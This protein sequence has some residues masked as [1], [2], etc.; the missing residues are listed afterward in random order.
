M[1]IQENLCFILHPVENNF[2]FPVDS[3]RKPMR[4]KGHEDSNVANSW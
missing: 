2:N 4:Q 1:K 3:L